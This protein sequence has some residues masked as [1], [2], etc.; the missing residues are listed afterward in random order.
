MLDAAV[1]FA[2]IQSA[3]SLGHVAESSIKSIAVN[4]DLSLH[5]NEQERQTNATVQSLSTRATDASTR[6]LYGKLIGANESSHRRREPNNTESKTTGANTRT[7]Q[8]TARTTAAAAISEQHAFH[9]FVRRSNTT[10][11][12]ETSSSHG[13]CRP[14]G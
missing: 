4:A 12:E 3:R 10:A 7:S 8:T 11:A 14:P 9:L 2:R 1:I 5:V 6:L 13:Q